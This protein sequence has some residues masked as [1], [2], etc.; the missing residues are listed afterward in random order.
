MNN[1]AIAYL[2][3]LQDVGQDTVAIQADTL[4]A[5]LEAL[6]ELRNDDGEP[7]RIET[8][9]PLTDALYC[10]TCDVEFE[11]ELGMTSLL[12]LAKELPRRVTLPGEPS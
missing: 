10:A 6:Q 9:M 12:N 3:A 5:L 2:K 7:E 4:I 1:P 11:L 8:D